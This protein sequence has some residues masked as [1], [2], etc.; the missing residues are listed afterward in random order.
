MANCLICSNNYLDRTYNGAV[1]L[2]GGSWQSALPIS[3]L[4]DRFLVRVAQSTDTAT[5]STKFNFD[6]RT[7]RNIRHTF[8]PSH[9]LQR[10]A[11]YRIRYSNTPQFSSCTVFANATVGANSVIFMAGVAGATINI[12]DA[13]T[14]NGN[15]QVYT[16]TNSVVIASSGAGTINISPSLVDAATAGEE[17][18]CHTGDF[19][20]P[21]RDSGRNK[22]H[23][24]VIDPLTLL[25]GDPRIWDGRYTDEELETINE[26]IVDY[27]A[28]PFI[29]RYG[30]IELFDTGNTDGYVWLSRLFVSLGYQ[31]TVN[32]AYGLRQGFECT[33]KIS[34]SLGDAQFYEVRAIRRTFSFE[35]NDISISEV[36]SNSYEAINYSGLDKQIVFS[37]DPSDTVQLARRT[38]LATFKQLPDFSYAYFNAINTP[39][40]LIEVIA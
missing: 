20:T 1:V 30:I 27:I 25:W 23:L 37:F 21:L 40:N 24:Q 18:E 34:N 31:P 5:D 8:I 10:N 15:T 33:T 17:V 3:N 7:P 19:T 32:A 26:P 39:Y 2:S 35:I 29:A 12:G 38:I 11:E 4:K 6:L 16:A 36:M 13:F 28:T 9:N 14:I 22:V